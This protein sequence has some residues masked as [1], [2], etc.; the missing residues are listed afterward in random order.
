[1]N[2]LIVKIIGVSR[3]CYWYK[4]RIG[5]Y[6]EVRIKSASDPRLSPLGYAGTYVDQ[7]YIYERKEDG[8][9]LYINYNDCV[10]CTRF[11]KI[12]KINDKLK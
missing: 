8:L 12:K 2:T 4:N 9:E 1:M 7:Y 6:V 10:D 11:Q 3:P 5:E